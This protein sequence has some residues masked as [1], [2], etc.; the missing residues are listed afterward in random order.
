MLIKNSYF[1]KC[2]VFH[3]I[4]L[5]EHFRFQAESIYTNGICDEN[6]VITFVF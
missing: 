5:K 1:T 6:I 4:T 3:L 2:A